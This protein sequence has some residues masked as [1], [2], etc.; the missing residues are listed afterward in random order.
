MDHLFLRVQFESN[1]S[2]SQSFIAAVINWTLIGA[3]II[4]YAYAA[5]LG[6]KLA[7]L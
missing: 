6:L 5:G 2:K 1:L 7:G 4:F 3:Q